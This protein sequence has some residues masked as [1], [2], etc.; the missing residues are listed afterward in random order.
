M[1]QGQCGEVRGL[2]AI[3]AALALALL[4]QD[5]IEL[6]L[7]LARLLVV[8]VARGLLAIGDSVLLI[9]TLEL[10]VGTAGMS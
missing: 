5:A 8:L 4:L 9:L 2:V 3:P 10:L 1:Q 7:P 6:A